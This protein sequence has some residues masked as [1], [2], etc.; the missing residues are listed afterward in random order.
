[1]VL[2]RRHPLGALL[3]LPLQEMREGRRQE[4]A[5]DQSPGPPCRVTT[6]APWRCLTHLEGARGS[7]G[8]GI[9]SNNWFDRGLLSILY[10]FKPSC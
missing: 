1:M 5:W 2:P 6:G 10:M 4:E 9:V 7:Q 8:M 3:R